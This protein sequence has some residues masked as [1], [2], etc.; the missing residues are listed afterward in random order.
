MSSS[1]AIGVDIGGTKVA[2]GVVDEHG[3]ITHRTRRETPERSTS[4]AIVEETIAA[5]VEELIDRQ[6]PADVVAV[7]VGAAGFVSE[8]RGTVLF[9]PHLSWRQEPLRSRL[10]GRVPWPVTVDNDANAAAWAERTFGAARGESHVVVITL[11]TGIGGALIIDGEVQRGRHGIAGEYGH[12]QVVP[13]GVRCECGNRGC[14]EQYASG[15]ALVREARAL[16]EAGSPVVADLVA[17]LGGDATALNGPVIT[18]AARDGDS[19]ARE[20]LAEIGDW[21]GVGMANLA[22]AFDPAMFVIGG[23]VSAADELLL[24]PARE[25]F[26]RQLPGRG[27]RP[28]ARIVRAQLGADAG[29]IG[30]AELARSGR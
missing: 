7:G 11:G 14:W 5:C 10:A 9:A 18:E 24:G 6:D 3:T 12:M 17:R 1:L 19:T 27:Y 13:G 25:A 22:A 26:R 16:I 4:P 30:A 21:L 23:G 29:L 20:M 15:N 2:A 8:D 28:E